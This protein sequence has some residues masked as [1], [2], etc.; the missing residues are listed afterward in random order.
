MTLSKRKDSSLGIQIYQIETLSLNLH[1][2]LTSN[3]K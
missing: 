1:Q 2:S 3:K